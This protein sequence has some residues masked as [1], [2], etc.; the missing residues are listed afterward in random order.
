MFEAL[1]KLVN[2][3][4]TSI[5]SLF[6]KTPIATPVMSVNTE[7]KHDALNALDKANQLQQR[8]LDAVNHVK[9]QGLAGAPCNRYLASACQYNLFAAKAAIKIKEQQYNN[10]RQFTV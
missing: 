10:A 8:A 2:Y 3:I 6:T 5:K 4:I 9:I 1:K 7:A